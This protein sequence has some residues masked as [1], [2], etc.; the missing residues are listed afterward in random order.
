MGGATAGERGDDGDDAEV[1]SPM[2]AAVSL[3]RNM[4]AN[5]DKFCTDA[6]RR[7]AGTCGATIIQSQGL[8]VRTDRSAHWAGRGTFLTS[9]Y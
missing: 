7:S 2:R 9:T 1:A 5:S 6:P 3:Q 4:Y 8:R